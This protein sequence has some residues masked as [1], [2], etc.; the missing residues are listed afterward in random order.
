MVYPSTLALFRRTSHRTSPT[1]RGDDRVRHLASVHTAVLWEA[2]DLSAV[3]VVIAWA[4]NAPLVS[5]SLCTSSKKRSPSLN[6]RSHC[7]GWWF[8][9]CT[10]CHINS[11]VHLARYRWSE[12]NEYDSA[13]YP[14]FQR[15]VHHLKRRLSHCTV[16]PLVGCLNRKVRSDNQF[17]LVCPQ[18]KAGVPRGRTFATAL[19]E[20]FLPNCEATVLRK[21]HGRHHFSCF[22]A[23][24][25]NHTC[26]NVDINVQRHS[27]NR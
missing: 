27:V 5:R 11:L 2:M 23:W 18:V 21:A 25:Q 6:R 1:H 10:I 7:S 9:P 12:P 22:H 15:S 26:L 14:C 16:S 3:I 19:V 13:I 4:R 24:F 20:A 17:S 8:H